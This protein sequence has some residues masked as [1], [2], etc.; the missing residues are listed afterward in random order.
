MYP[1]FWPG[2]V[3]TICIPMHLQFCHNSNQMQ[4]FFTVRDL[5]PSIG[6]IRPHDKANMTSE[7]G[8]PKDEAHADRKVGPERTICI[9]VLGRRWREGAFIQCRYIVPRSS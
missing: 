6:R 7:G 5:F 2:T 9:E 4:V 8:Q 1:N 3:H